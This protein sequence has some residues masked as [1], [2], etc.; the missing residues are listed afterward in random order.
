MLCL[1]R[2]RYPCLSIDVMPLFQQIF[3]PLNWCCA[4][5]A[6]DIL[7]SQLMLC[8]F[9]SRY[10]CLSI[11]VVPLSLQIF[12]PRASSL[13]RVQFTETLYLDHV[14]QLI[15]EEQTLYKTLSDKVILRWF[16]ISVHPGITTTST[17]NNEHSLSLSSHSTR[18]TWKNKEYTWKTWNYQ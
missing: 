1:C 13:I 15:D 4:S 17:R 14:I 2:C 9:P 7:A 18:K 16:L 8:L 10:S 5:V 3:V 12:V 6:A 11:D